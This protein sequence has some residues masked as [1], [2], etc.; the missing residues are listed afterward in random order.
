MG[1][2][3]F[4]IFIN[5]LLFI[6]LNSNIGSYADD[7]Q[8][9][10]SNIDLG[11]LKGIIESDLHTAHDWFSHNG[12]LLNASKSTSMLMSRNHSTLDNF[13]FTLCNDNISISTSIKLLGVTIDNKLNFNEH[14][15][16]IIRKV[17]NQ[18]QVMKRHKRLIPEK[19]KIILYK[20]YFLPHLNYYSLV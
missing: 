20:A 5:D 19:A 18:L 1:P 14:I 17:S 13:S 4:N 9:Y 11:T 16:D 15:A 3:L 8:L 7:T 12:L 6:N 10:S 2:L